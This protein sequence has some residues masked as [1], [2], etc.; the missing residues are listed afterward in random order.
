MKATVFT[1]RSIGVGIAACMLVAATAGL[2]VGVSWGMAAVNG[3]SVGNVLAQESGATDRAALEALY[4]ATDGS[5]WITSTNWK[6]GEPL[7]AWHGVTTDAAGRVTRLSLSSNELRGAIPV[8]LGGLANLRTLDL[9]SN[10]LSGA[11][12]VELGGLA[13]LQ[14]LSLFE[15]ELERADPR[16][17]EQLDLPRGAVSQREYVERCDPGGAGRLDQPRRS[18]SRR[19]YIEWSDAGGVGQIGQPPEAV[20]RRQ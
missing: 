14:R 20:S 19:E 7:S 9:F 2:L 15:N 16:G 8:E 6:T 5:N 11:I 10:A 18:G 1:E 3:L 12:P 13:N 17:V 4:E